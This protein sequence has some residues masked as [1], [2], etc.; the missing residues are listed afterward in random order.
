MHD[1]G[2]SPCRWIVYLEWRQWGGQGEGHTSLRCVSLLTLCMRDFPVDVNVRRKCARLG[3][4]PWHMCLWGHTNGKG[5]GSMGHVVWSGGTGGG[6][7]EVFVD[8][9]GR[10]YVI[11]C[12]GVQECWVFAAF[13]TAH[14]APPSPCGC[15]WTDLCKAGV[16]PPAGTLSVRT[17]NRAN[18]CFCGLGRG[19]GVG[20]RCVPLLPLHVQ[21]L[22]VLGATYAQS[23]MYM[24]NKIILSRAAPPPP[25]L[26]APPT[27]TP[28]PT[29]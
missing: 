6:G 1:W 15:E 17:V 13:D 29:L 22:A 5:E 12:Q 16:D 8:E 18:V 28:P 20:A 24:H 10:R 9:A 19:G 14:E 7:A 11:T 4:I 26:P 25:P 27:P 2:G 23:V 3:W 21:A